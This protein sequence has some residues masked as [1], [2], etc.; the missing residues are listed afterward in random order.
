LL[1]KADMFIEGIAYGGSVGFGRQLCQSMSTQSLHEQKGEFQKYHLDQGS[2]FS[3]E[4]VTT[5]VN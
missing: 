1:S 5:Q 4:K 2:L 3:T